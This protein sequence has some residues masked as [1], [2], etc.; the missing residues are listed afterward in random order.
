MAM[1]N[2]IIACLLVILP[3]EV[4]DAQEIGSGPLVLSPGVA[5]AYDEFRR[6]DGRLF[7]AVSKDGR[8]AGWSY[9][10]EFGPCNR[11]KARSIAVRACERESEG[12]PCYIYANMNGVLWKGKV[13]A[14]KAPAAGPSQRQGLIDCRFPD[15]SLVITTTERCWSAGGTPE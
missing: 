5:Q 1:R 10:K 4:A 14:P 9:C 6:L 13:S 3:L 15:G 2:T 8:T 12:V 11:T 7:F